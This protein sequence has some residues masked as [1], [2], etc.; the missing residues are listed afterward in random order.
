MG[1]ADAMENRAYN[2]HYGVDITATDTMKN[3]GYNGHY[4]EQW[5]QRRLWRERER[6]RERGGGIV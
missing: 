1:I 3:S 5:I 6:E 2:W 4:G